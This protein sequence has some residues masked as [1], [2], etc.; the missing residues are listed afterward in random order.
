M[1][2]MVGL[3]NNDREL[4]ECIKQNKDSIYEAYFSWGDFA[5]GRTNQLLSGEY[6]PWELQDI[7]RGML[8]E[9]FEN[10]KTCKENTERVT[11]TGK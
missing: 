7:Q 3:K 10:S 8:K 6:T 1:K 2:F 4:L 11:I 9:L 5:N